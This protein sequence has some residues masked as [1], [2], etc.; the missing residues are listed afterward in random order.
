MVPPQPLA[1]GID[2]STDMTDAAP[3]PYPI[4]VAVIDKS[5][6]VVRGLQSLFAEDGRFEL[7]ASASDGERLLD[8][9]DRFRLD[10]VLSGW[11]M[12]Y[13]DGRTFLERL[14]EHERPPRVIVY[15]GDPD[16][17]VPREAMRLG[18][19]GFCAKNEPPERLLQ[20]LDSVARGSMVF[21]FMD[22]RGLDDDPLAELTPRER[23][24]LGQLALGLTN[25]EI[26][27]ALGVSPNTV[28]FHL[29]NLYEKLDVRNRAEAVALHFSAQQT[30]C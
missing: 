9:L 7:V 26:A 10:I 28:K 20:V 25:N 27:K 5:P 21:P 2:L 23:E 22:V 15:T 13:C 14:R 19:A 6:L 4:E 18:A 16:P 8:A 30:S 11:I 24:L 29:R 17:S 3:L 1:R 12:P